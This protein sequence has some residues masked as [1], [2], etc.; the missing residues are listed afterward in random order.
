MLPDGAPDEG[1][2]QPEPSDAS[3][4]GTS[5]EHEDGPQAEFDPSSLP[6]E[7]QEYLTNREREMQGDYTRKTQA[8]AEER[9]QAQFAQAFHEAILDPDHPQHEEALGI[10]QQRGIL[11]IEDPDPGLEDEDAMQRR[12][13]A[14]EQRLSQEDQQRQNQQLEDYVLGHVADGIQAIQDSEGREFSDEEL[15]ILDTVARRNPGPDGLP[16]VDYANKVLKAHNDQQ[17]KSW[18][19][20]KRTPRPPGGGPAARQQFDPRDP[21]QRREASIAAAEAA[22]AAGEQ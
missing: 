4:E 12:L 17:K 5:V 22:I 16:N 21:A 11:D 13:D 14:L 10:L 2:D 19:S 3:L 6:P 15:T 7:V 8:V 1:Q 18:V 20:S 9:R